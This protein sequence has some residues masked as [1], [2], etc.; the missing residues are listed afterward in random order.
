[1]DRDGWVVVE[2]EGGGR[3]VV[4]LDQWT[5]TGKSVRRRAA[6]RW[7]K[8]QMGWIWILALGGQAFGDH[9]PWLPGSWINSRT[10]T[11]TIG[12]TLRSM[13]GVESSYLKCSNSSSRPTCGLSTRALIV[14]LERNRGRL[15]LPL[16]LRQ[17]D[18]RQESV[19]GWDLD[20]RS[21]SCDI[22]PFLPPMHWMRSLLDRFGRLLALL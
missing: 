9:T 4:V 1:M 11:G 6:Y 15:Q 14:K 21:F 10:D 8:G 17:S 7:S 2:E 20:A 18:G 13:S 3:V 22:V 5:V 16:L 12:A 19:L